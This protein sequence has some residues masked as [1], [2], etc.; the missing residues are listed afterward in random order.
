MHTIYIFGLGPTHLGQMPKEVYDRISN[1]DKLYLRTL[2]HP[3][4]QELKKEGLDIVSFDDKYEEFDE[5]FERVYP[6]IVEELIHLAETKD[7]YYGVPGHPAVA[8]TTVQLLLNDYEQTKIIG[9]KSFI[10][11]LFAAVNIDPI[12]GFQLMDSFDLN[13]DHIFPGQH[14]IVMQVF[15]S[16]I[17]S[18]VKLAL[19][20]IYP[21]DHQIAIVDAAGSPEESVLWMP[22]YELDYF[23]GVHNLRSVYVPPLERDQAVYSFATLQS[24]TDEVLG[25]NGD[26]WAKQLTGEELLKYFQE[27]LD[28]LKAAYAKDDMNN[29]VEEL[30][31]LL[32]QLLYQ[33]GIGENEELF[34]LEEV[35]EGINKKMRRR[36]PHVFDGVKAETPEE[37]DAIWQKIKEQERKGNL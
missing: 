27:E 8:E 12:Q 24:Y 10:D 14:L 35:L 13:S 29:V 9:G 28:E 2:K 22:L 34:S 16:L 5:D 30:G 37:V 32:M 23:E 31:D 17:A 3:A 25:E 4:A 19:M 15:H 21:D 18:E 6:A 7:V 36:H 20:E 11:D 26:V 33:T 1:Q